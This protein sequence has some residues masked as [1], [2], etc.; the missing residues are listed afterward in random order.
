MKSITIHGIDEQ[1]DKEIQAQT[2]KSGL[3]QNGTVKL[4][5]RKQLL[6]K[7][8]DAKRKAFLDLFGK[9]SKAD[10]KSF[11][12]AVKELES[13]DDGDWKA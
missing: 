9:W 3:S 6:S 1:L 8:A 4:L 2:K 7:P 11:R 13:V 5:L 12:T 10:T